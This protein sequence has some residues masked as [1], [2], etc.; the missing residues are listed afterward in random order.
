MLKAKPC[1]T[2]GRIYLLILVDAGMELM[3][4]RFAVVVTS[5]KKKPY[6]YLD[7]RK[8]DFD[9]DFD[10]FKRAIQELHVSNLMFVCF[11]KAVFLIKFVR[12]DAIGHTFNRS[13]RYCVRN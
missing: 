4:S 2:V 5:M 13:M 3:A 9:S 10:E 6:D 7:Q 8:M 12:C 1:L 11:S